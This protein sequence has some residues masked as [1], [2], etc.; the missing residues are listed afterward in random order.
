MLKKVLSLML[1]VLSSGALALGPVYGNSPQSEDH[2]AAKMK[3]NIS[4][5]GVHAPVILKLIDGRKLSGNIAEIDG[6]TFVLLEP[7]PGDARLTNR[8]VIAYAEV[9]QVK[10][11]GSTGG[12]NLGPAFLIAGVVILLAKVMH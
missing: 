5:L 12:A 4:K 1:V 6:D 2:G 11:N 9:Q 8:K 10:Y 7:A 3:R